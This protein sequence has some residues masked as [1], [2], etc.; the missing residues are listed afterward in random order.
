MGAVSSRKVLG[1]QHGVQCLA[2][3]HFNIKTLNR[4]PQGQAALP[5]ETVQ[6]IFRKVLKT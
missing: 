2:Q 4:Q 6:K 5:Q 3:G 1:D